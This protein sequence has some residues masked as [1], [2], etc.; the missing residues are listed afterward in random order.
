MSFDYYFQTVFFPQQWFIALIISI[1][2]IEIDSVY[3]VYSTYT[4]RLIVLRYEFLCFFFHLLINCVTLLNTHQWLT[5]NNPATMVRHLIL[6]FS[7]FCSYIFRY[8]DFASKET[9]AT[10]MHLVKRIP[11]TKNFIRFFCSSFDVHIFDA[12]VPHSVHQCSINFCYSFHTTVVYI[13]VYD[14]CLHM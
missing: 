10:C 9:R 12:V 8:I 1:F 7:T 5:T 2:Y 14:I 6:I 4:Y 13:Y 3:C 11:E